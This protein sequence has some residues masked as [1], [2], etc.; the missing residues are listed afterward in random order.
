MPKGIAEDEPDRGA[1]ATA[2][3]I[4]R[5]RFW[6][7]PGFMRAL[8]PRTIL[9]FVSSPG[10][11]AAQRQI[12]R[13]VIARINDDKQV[14]RQRIKFRALLWEDLPPGPTER[15]DFQKRISTLLSR[16]GYDDYGIYLGFF[17]GRLGTPTP[18]YRSGTIEEFETSR[19]QRQRTGSPAELL[20]YFLDPEATAVPAV[21][22]FRYELTVRGYL[23]TTMPTEA[24]ED[25][26]E[27][28]LLEIAHAWSGWRNRL[29]RIGPKIGRVAA[30]ATVLVVLAVAGLNAWSYL[31]IEADLMAGDLSSAATRWRDQSLVMLVGRNAAQSSINTAIARSIWS[32]ADLDQ[33]LSAM[34]RWKDNPVFDLKYP[35]V[36]N[37]LDALAAQTRTA[38]TK[39]AYSDDDRRAFVLWDRGRALGLWSPAETGELLLPVAAS[40]FIGAL[41]ASGIGPEQWTRKVLRT[42]ERAELQRFARRLVTSVTEPRR[43]GADR[44]RR[45]GIAILADNQVALMHLASEAA[46]EAE[47]YE[48]PEIEGWIA[49]GPETMVADW[50]GRS[51]KATTPPQIIGKVIDGIRRRESPTLVAALIDRSLQSDAP[52]DLEAQ[53]DNLECL[54]A[55]CSAFANARLAA[56]AASAAPLSPGIEL[57]LPAL[58]ASGLDGLARERLAD[59]LARLLSSG[60]SGPNEIRALSRLGTEAAVKALDAYRERL[61]TRQVAFGFPGAPP[62]LSTTLPPGGTT[63]GPG[64]M[65]RG[66]LSSPPKWMPESF[67]L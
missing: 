61:A 28:N 8:S 24:F 14:A 63:D 40:R 53:L 12:A 67:S 13:D 38:V 49:L 25:R 17:K 50:V 32:E 42:F 6:S 7:E 31:Q 62:L 36:E 57:L 9:V 58:D 41:V 37:L 51:I 54:P 18:R 64:S 59:K 21:A 1:K 34:G 16:Y 10:D 52:K 66:V 60:A 26:L 11:C 29:R 2:V 23:P 47:G 56:W 43:W 15:N 5:R 3:A 39:A 55:A 30:V 46:Q 35:A 20:I 27:D 22:E 45:V 65:R 48:Q 19:W 44:V 33:R 4:S